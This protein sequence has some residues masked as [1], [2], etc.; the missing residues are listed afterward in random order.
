M[1]NEINCEVIR[2]LLPPYVDQL[3]SPSSCILV[4]EH[5]KACEHCKKALE[6]LQN[7]E[8]AAPVLPGE[9]LGRV[10]KQINKKRIWTAL[11]SA[12]AACALAFFGF[13]LIMI[14]YAMHY[15]PALFADELITLEKSD[16][17]GYSGLFLIFSQGENRHFIKEPGHIYRYD[18]VIMENGEEIYVVYM[19]WYRNGFDILRDVFLGSRAFSNSVST[20]WHN[21]MSDRPPATRLY[22]YPHGDIDKYWQTSNYDYDGTRG[23]S[24]RTPVLERS[25]LI[26]EW[27]VE[28]YG[29]PM[30]LREIQH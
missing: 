6:Q 8:A 23:W 18:D 12:I 11:L 30:D 19:T 21:T 14:P 5:L 16:Q 20:P 17:W 1:Y 15:D 7:E 26:W 10:K 25:Y 9:A 24:Q 4:E 27:D 22:Y 2:D 29:E 3:T 28:A 13:Y